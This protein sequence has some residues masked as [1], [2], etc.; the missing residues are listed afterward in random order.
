MGTP[1]DK[2]RGANPPVPQRAGTVNAN[3]AATASGFWS[4]YLEGGYFDA[5]G[6][7][8]P[9]YV[10]RKHIEPLARTMAD[11]KL[12]T[13]QVRRFFNHCR[14]IEAKL[15]ALGKSSELVERMWASERTTFIRLDA[16]AADALAKQKVP[17]LFH[18]FI[19]RNVDA[20]TTHTDFLRGFIPHFEALVGFG[21]AHFTKTEKG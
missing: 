1:Q 8:R 21:S 16:F 5:D 17:N 14:L 12:S 7:L 9:E 15:K 11:A 10:D 19:Q 13:T 3:P 4:G 20:V 6:N 18:D 2:P